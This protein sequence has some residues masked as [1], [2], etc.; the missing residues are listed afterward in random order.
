MN[1]ESEI[2]NSDLCKKYR[3]QA[4]GG[5]R[6]SSYPFIFLINNSA[7]KY[8]TDMDVNKDGTNSLVHYQITKEDIHKNNAVI[9]HKR[10]KGVYHSIFLFNKSGKKLSFVG[11]YEF[12]GVDKK[13][14][15]ND[16]IIDYFILSKVDKSLDDEKVYF[17][18]KTEPVI[19]L[20]ELGDRSD[21]INGVYNDEIIEIDMPKNNI[22]EGDFLDANFN[23]IDLNRIIDTEQL[24]IDKK[25]IMRLNFRMGPEAT[26]AERRVGQYLFFLSDLNSNIQILSLNESEET[27]ETSVDEAYLYTVNVGCALT[28]FLVLVKSKQAKVWAIDWGSGR[29]YKAQAVQHIQDCIE[30][31]KTTFFA[32]NEFTISK[33][34]ISHADTDHYN[35][36]DVSMID[37]DTEVWVS[38]YDFIAGNYPKKIN[39]I[40]NITSK[41]KTPLCSNST[42]R[43]KV[44]H[45]DQPIVYGPSTFAGTGFYPA[46]NKNDVS[47]IIAITINGIRCIFTGDIMQTG[48]GWYQTYSDVKGIITDIYLHSHHG[49]DNG[50]ITNIPNVS[51]CEYDTVTFEID[52]L[53]TRDNAYPGNI[54]SPNMLARSEYANTY[55]I[56]LKG[57]ELKYYKTDVLLKKVT[58]VYI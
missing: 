31:I 24:D 8:T 41:F 7:Y 29:S 37:A 22:N 25:G 13:P 48:W 34:F 40:K 26:P 17:V 12:Q 19:S 35:R 1:F 55:S 18:E 4:V 46:T 27:E 45:P 30:D 58:P 38:G 2:E 11:E 5:I 47:P 16:K 44:L 33:L 14:D 21:F 15:N 42:G 10:L 52:I 39:R 49:S 9:N 32:G 36:I 20:S 43:I 50:F 57:R 54:P 3:C 51:D 23:P 53:S 6:L 56:Q 28:N